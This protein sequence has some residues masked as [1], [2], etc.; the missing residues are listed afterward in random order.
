[1]H[2]I[3][4]L[5]Y[6]GTLS[7]LIASIDPRLKRKIAGQALCQRCVSIPVRE[8]ATPVAVQSSVGGGSQDP[9]ACAG[10]RQQLREGQA[11]V[12]LDRQWHV[13]CF[14]CH[15]CDTVLHGEY[16]GKWVYRKKVTFFFKFF[17]SISRIFIEFSKR[18]RYCR[19]GVPY[20]E[21]DYQKQFGVKCAY[22]NRYIS[23]KVLQAGENHHFHPTCARCT[24]C[25]D[26]FGDGEEMFLQGAAIWHPRCGPGPTQPNG[27]ANGH[28]ETH[29]PQH[30]NHH[31]RSGAESER[32][33]SS[34]SEMQV[35]LGL[36]D[37]EFL[38]HILLGY[39]T[40]E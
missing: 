16:M 21:K 14:K 20:C 18:Y 28:S 25:G 3:C 29:T 6:T 36:I 22:C 38:T 40:E 9:G 32:I 8:A 37:R 34:A 11:L 2:S 1:M 24:K 19:D 17:L 23:G 7:C 31:H 30:H 35:S 26:P 10:C 4:S 13:W 39:W 33:S 12:A 5:L 27:V 15:T